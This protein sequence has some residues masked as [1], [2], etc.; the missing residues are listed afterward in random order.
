MKGHLGAVLTT[1]LAAV[2]L[3]LALL[4]AAV[5]AH[6]VQKREAATAVRT[7]PTNRYSAPGNRSGIPAWVPADKVQQEKPLPAESPEGRTPPRRQQE[8]HRS[9]PPPSRF[10]G[11]PP[12]LGPQPARKA[13]A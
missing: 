4:Q 2:A 11:A 5:V 1:G 12:R 3:A 6:G 13:A 8:E 7:G 9:P 10:R